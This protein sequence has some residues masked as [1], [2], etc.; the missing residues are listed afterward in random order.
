MLKHDRGVQAVQV[1]Q[2][3]RGHALLLG[4]PGQLLRLGQRRTE[5]IGRTIV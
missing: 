5:R 2:R 3:D 1:G 4:E